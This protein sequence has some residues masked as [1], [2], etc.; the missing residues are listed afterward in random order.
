M[1]IDIANWVKSARINKK[2]TQENLAL[3]L[4]FSTKASVSAIETRKNK[5]TFDT[6]IK[7]SNICDYPLPYQEVREIK[8]LDSD[9]FFEITFYD[10]N[11]AFPLTKE[12]AEMNIKKISIPKFIFD[13]SNIKEHEAIAIKMEGNSMHPVLPNNTILLINTSYKRIID[14]QIYAVIQSDLLRIRKLYQLPDGKIK[15]SAYNNDEYPSENTDL[16][17]LE[18]V[19]KVFSWI[20][21]N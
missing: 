3:E 8:V 17:N 4:G 18:V 10:C 20:A 21:F 2:M 13:N 5:P 16:K 1:S 7:I 14:G 6:L 11:D 12:N 15:I 9:N 19:G